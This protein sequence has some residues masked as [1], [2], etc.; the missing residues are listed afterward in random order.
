[1]AKLQIIFFED[2]DFWGFVGNVGSF[3]GL[4]INA[5]GWVLELA[6]GVA[7]RVINF[8]AGIIIQYV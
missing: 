4:M 6:G 3:L 1:V 7:T 5:V 2:R 8:S